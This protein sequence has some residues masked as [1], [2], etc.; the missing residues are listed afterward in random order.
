[1][2]LHALIAAL[3]LAL[4]CSHGSPPSQDQRSGSASAA[5]A[6]PAPA[7]QAGVAAVGGKAPDGQLVDAKNT[8]LALN[9]VLKQHPQTIVVF[10]R[11]FF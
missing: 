5:T 2:K 1:M 11:G 6:A 3:V 8:K 9:D 10:Y 7:A 4:G